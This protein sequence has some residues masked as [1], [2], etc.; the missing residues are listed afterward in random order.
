MWGLLRWLPTLMTLRGRREKEGG[1]VPHWVCS[2]LGDQ[3]GGPLP[4]RG[5]GGAGIT[6]IL[7]AAFG[8][9][10]NDTKFVKD[11]ILIGG[12]EGEEQ[13][14]TVMRAAQKLWETERE[15]KRKLMIKM[16]PLLFRGLHRFYTDLLAGEGWFKACDNH[17]T[18][19]PQKVKNRMTAQCSNFTSEYTPG[20]T[21]KQGLRRN[22]CTP[23]VTAV[24][25]TTARRSEQRKCPSALE[26]I[27][28]MGSIC[29]MENSS[30]LKRNEFFF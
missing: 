22:I 12:R 7:P 25:F 20:R 16:F 18:R 10:C 15:K 13:K 1:A 27:N 28:Q 26:W 23:M 21:E 4:R 2:L 3:L 14:C 9:L 8:D 17:S 24:L 29:S 5:P 11:F 30:A 19:V 6:R